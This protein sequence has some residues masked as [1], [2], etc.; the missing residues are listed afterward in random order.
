MAANKILTYLLD[1]GMEI[2]VAQHDLIG[3]SV[4]VEGV[5]ALQLGVSFINT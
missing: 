5:V 4:D 1:D 3:V 2:G